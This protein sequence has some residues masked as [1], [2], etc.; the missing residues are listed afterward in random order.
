MEF[1]QTASTEN[2]LI[3]CRL[4]TAFLSSEAQV[5]GQT[6]S[7]QSKFDSNRIRHSCFNHRLNTTNGDPTRFGAAKR[8]LEQLKQSHERR[9]RRESNQLE[10]HNCR[11]MSRMSISTQ[12]NIENT[13]TIIYSNCP[14]V[15]DLQTL[16]DY[17]S[18]MGWCKP[19]P[20]HPCLRNSLKKMCNFIPGALFLRFRITPL[21]L[22][23]SLFQ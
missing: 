4:S 11:R 15:L 16:G 20:F 7:T 13:Q 23:V 3:I 21:I 1:V 2:R 8:H 12:K 17:M 5:G 22:I 19:L 14:Q 6:L 9:E 10:I 18:T